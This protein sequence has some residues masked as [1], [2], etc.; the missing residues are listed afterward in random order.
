M[1]ADSGWGMLVGLFVFS[2]TLVGGVFLMLAWGWFV[3][4]RGTCAP[5]RPRYALY[6]FTISV[7][8]P[9]FAYAGPPNWS[10]T[11]HALWLFTV[12]SIVAASFVL[13]HY[14]GSYALG[15][16]RRQDWF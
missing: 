9:P 13:Y 14:C 3:V 2:T 6:A 1:G 8:L 7:L 15:P 5:G 10:F 4:D 16:W 12:L 11:S